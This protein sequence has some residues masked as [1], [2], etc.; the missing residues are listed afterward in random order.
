METL[1]SVLS[2]FSL[3]KFIS[4]YWSKKAL[5]V[6]GDGSK[7]SNLFD[8]NSFNRIISENVDPHPSVIV[9]SKGK[10]IKPSSN[11]ELVE[12]AQKGASVVIENAGKYDFKLSSYLNRITKETFHN[13]R[14]NAYLSFLGHEAYKVHYDT[15]DVYILQ[16]EGAKK[17]EVY[18]ST[19]VNPIFYQ[20]N[21]SVEAPPDQSKYLETTLTPGD[22]FYVPRGHW[23]RVMTVDE[24]SLHLTLA[25]F[26]RTGILFL[27]W[28]TNEL[29]E[30]P[31]FRRDIPFPD[32]N[33]HEEKFSSQLKNFI[34]ILCSELNEVIKKPDLADNFHDY[35]S[36]TYRY[37][38]QISFPSI[39]KSY[40]PSELRELKFYV[41]PKLH[42]IKNEKNIISLIVKDKILRFNSKALPIVKYIMESKT[43]LLENLLEVSSLDIDDISQILNELLKNRIVM[44]KF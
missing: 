26:P 42:R 43:F 19:I 15:H 39:V 22:F 18:D 23:H 8:W 33:I 16:I 13:T 31:S 7:Y 2:P 24:P 38:D 14:I 20:K 29:T 10:R 5:Y 11:S 9:A 35:L 41:P 37:R 17:W 4:E 6:K 30:Y 28:L 25:I 44:V 34:D 3:N 40:S 1:A 36:A 32:S 27:K 21:H 12:W